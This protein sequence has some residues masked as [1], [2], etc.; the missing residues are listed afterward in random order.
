MPISIEVPSV[1]NEAEATTLM[2]HHLMLAAAYFEAT[3]DEQGRYANDIMRG[4]GL[5]KSVVNAVNSFINVL[6][7]YY[8]N[9]NENQMKD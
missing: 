9:I 6:C 2:L 1:A 8:E 3:D 4:I 7:T 5:N